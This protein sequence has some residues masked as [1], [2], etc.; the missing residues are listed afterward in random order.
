MTKNKN[1]IEAK[2]KNQQRI[3]GKSSRR[4][5]QL[6]VRVEKWNRQVKD[7]DVFESGEDGFR[8][9]AGEGTVD[10][11]DEASE[12]VSLG[13]GLSRHRRWKPCIVEMHFVREN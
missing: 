13:G 9:I 3:R 11:G 1:E 4:K 7:G 10:G 12:R 8:I 2:S 5:Q 6:K